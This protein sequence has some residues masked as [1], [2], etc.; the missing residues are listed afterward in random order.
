MARERL[1]WPRQERFCFNQFAALPNLHE[2][3]IGRARKR[4]SVSRDT[5]DR[6]TVWIGAI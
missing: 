3:G 4:S 6:V 5:G 1:V 2:P